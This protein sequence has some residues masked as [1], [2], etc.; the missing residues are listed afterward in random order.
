MEC[1]VCLLVSKTTFIIPVGSSAKGQRINQY[2]DFSFQNKKKYIYFTGT[3][4]AIRRHALKVKKQK[5]K[6]LKFLFF[7]IIIFYTRRSNLND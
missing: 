1:I 5:L 3:V 2:K 7:T 6:G 4:V